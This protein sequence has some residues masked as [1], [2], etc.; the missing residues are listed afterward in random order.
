MFSILLK[1]NKKL[2]WDDAVPRLFYPTG[3]ACFL[4]LNLFYAFLLEP[5][6][7]RSQQAEHP[8]NKMP[9]KKTKVCFADSAKY[10]MYG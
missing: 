5:L 1:E 9:A 2:R 6:S 3:C 4:L 8:R 7:F 10:E